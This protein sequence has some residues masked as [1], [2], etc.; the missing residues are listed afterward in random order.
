MPRSDDDSSLH[1]NFGSFDEIEEAAADCAPW[2][3]LPMIDLT[4]S[5]P[6]ALP[7]DES[8]PPHAFAAAAGDPPTV[9]SGLGR[10]QIWLNG[11]VLMCACPV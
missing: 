1:F 10:G 7:E 9:P 6:L 11:G 8:P 4:S 3:D 5:E 2:A